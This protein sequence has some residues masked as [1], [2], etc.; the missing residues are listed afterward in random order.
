MRE[1][2]KVGA[3]GVRGIVGDSFTPQLACAFAQAFGAFVGRGSVVVG[4]DTRPSGKMIEAAV[5]AGL[6]SVGCKP[7]LT[8]IA[9]TPTVLFLTRHL[10]ARGGI[11]ITASHNP[12]AWNALKFVDTD[13]TFLSATRA[14]ELFDIYYQQEFPLVTETELPAVGRIERPLAEHFARVR[15][16]VRADAIR[17]RRFKVAVDC[18]NGVGALATRDFLESQLGCEVVTVF[19]EPSGKFEREPEP[20]PQH[21]SALCDLVAREKCAIGFAQDPDGDRLALVSELGRPMG[22]DMTLAFAVQQALEHHGV[23]P[24]AINMTASKS[25]EEI[26]RARGAPV[27]RTRVGE[28]NVTAAILEHRCVIGGEHTGGVIVPAVHPCRDSFTAMAMIL[29]ML[30]LSG[31]TPSQI[32]AGIP[33]FVTVREKVPAPGAKTPHVLRTLR[34]LYGSHEQNLM[35]GLYID[36][37]DAWVHVRRSNT[38]TVLRITAEAKTR[39]LAEKFAR[40]FRAHIDDALAE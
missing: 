5:V 32:R 15:D 26:A 27:V 25:V 16:Y 3:A 31:K 22:E 21:L 23:G 10:A 33:E 35:D 4:R 38:E 14:E 29:E 6:Q 24:V 34:R 1:S 20:L 39:D 40:E 12:S 2:L 19:E 13:G 9:P 11:A 28:T 37:G 7:L 18:C 8:G 36:F 30:A 17:A